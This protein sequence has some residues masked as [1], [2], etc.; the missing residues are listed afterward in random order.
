[1]RANSEGT[2]IPI[3]ITAAAASSHHEASKPEF[4]SSN[5]GRASSLIHTPWHMAET[6]QHILRQYN[7][8]ETAAWI[9]SVLEHTASHV[10]ALQFP[11]ELLGDAGAV[12]RALQGLAGSH[13]DI[14]ILADTTYN[15]LSVDEVASQHVHAS[16]IV[17]YGRASLSRT[18][19]RIPVYYVFPREERFRFEA[20]EDVSLAVTSTT[21]VCFVD[22]IYHHGLEEVTGY[23]RS[24]LFSSANETR[25]PVMMDSDGEPSVGGYAR[26]NEEQDSKDGVLYAWYGG[27]ESPAREQLM[28]TYNARDWISIDPVKGTVEHGLPLRTRQT[29]RKRYF[30]V[31]KARQANI[32]GLLVGT[33]AADGYKE[34]INSLRVAATEAG[35]KTYT[36]LMGKPSPAK[37]ANFPEI[38]VFVLVADPQGHIL[39]SKEYYAPIITPYEA[40]LAFSDDGEWE[41]HKYSLDLIPPVRVSEGGQGRAEL[42][43]GALV[44]QAQEALQVADIRGSTKDIVVSSS[45]EYLVHKRTWK[46][47]ESGSGPGEKKEATV[48][49]KGRS[50]RAAGY[51]E[52]AD[53]PS[54]HK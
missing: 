28:L 50:G 14:Y 29:L 26:L 35:K 1:M 53:C 17:H 11:D 21:V 39:D 33:L 22:Q 41:Q 18:T 25:F 3:I 51:D 19:G 30:L 42:E 43:C 40:M 37:L 13:V 36:L 47:V 34:S 4:R 38:E 54:I 44:M 16:C 20:G 7:I 8:Q 10:V 15:S 52:G 32:V 5:R 31:D 45:A 9:D 6:A 49:S 48:I 12:S 24:E 27:N 2:R 23:L 46:G